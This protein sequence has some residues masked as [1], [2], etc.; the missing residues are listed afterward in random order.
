MHVTQKI[1]SKNREH[2]LIFVFVIILFANGNLVTHLSRD[3]YSNYL[4]LD[5]ANKS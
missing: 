4:Y 1:N 3:T 2:K 5:G